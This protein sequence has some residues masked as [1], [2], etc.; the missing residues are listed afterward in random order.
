MIFFIKTTVLNALPR[1]EACFQCSKLEEDFYEEARTL[2][3]QRCSVVDWH[4]GLRQLPGRRRSEAAEA[5][6]SNWHPE[7]ISSVCP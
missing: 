5:V 2:H 4:D 7:P 1:K 3:F 6:R